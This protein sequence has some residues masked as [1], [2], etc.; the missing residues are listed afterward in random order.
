MVFSSMIFLWAFLPIVFIL[1]KIAGKS[2]KLQ[3]ILLLAASLLFYAWGEPRYMWLLL[4]S[5]L[6]NYAL[7]LFMDG[8]QGQGRR[9]FILIAGI[10]VNLGILGY[11]KYFNFFINTLNKIFSRELL[12]MKD[13]ALPLGVSF[14][15]FQA[16]TYLIDLYK[17]KYPAQKN[18]LNMALYFSFFPKIT[19]GPIEKYRDFEKQLTQR[20]QSLTL[21]GEGIRRFVYGLAKKVIIADTL[22]A[23][24]DRIYGLDLGNINGVLA[25]VAIIFY[26]LQLYYDF[27]GYSDM[28]VGLGKMFGFHLTEN[29]NYPYIA[30]TITDFWR[31]WHISLTSWFREYLYFPLG[32]NRKGKVRTYINISIIFIATGLWHGASW[33]FI[34]WGI[35]H[36]FFMVLERLGLGRILEKTKVVKHVYTILVLCVGWTFFRVGDVGLT[37]QYLKRMFLPWMYTASGYAVQELVT[38]RAFFVAA[39][40][41][42]G[43][44]LLQKAAVKIMPRTEKFKNSTVELVFCMLLLVYSVMLMVSSTYSAF[45]YMNF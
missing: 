11:Y 31:R 22:G 21:M 5:I 28:A 18:V 14:F 37:L 29:F 3:N 8:I 45:I 13:I 24:V 33:D 34:C 43:C 20:Q 36:G 26:S 4:V 40:G 12:S 35:F 15:T 38:N 23:C 1:D 2:R 30:S 19:Q 25:W 16:M 10:L 39:C 7:G 41:I 32:G 6:A 9:K 27:S 42:L 17:K 44:G